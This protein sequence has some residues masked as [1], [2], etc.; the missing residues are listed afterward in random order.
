MPVFRYKATKTKPEEFTELGAVVAKDEKAATFK[1]NQYGFNKVRLK[2][3]R[4]IAA[5][6]KRFTADIK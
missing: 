4:G 6:W 1:L 2:R 3:I 5:L